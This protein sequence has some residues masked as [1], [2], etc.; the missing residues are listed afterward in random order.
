MLCGYIEI[1]RE[2]WTFSEELEKFKD[3]L[4]NIGVKLKIEAGWAF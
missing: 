4:Y 1:K 3:I 2:R